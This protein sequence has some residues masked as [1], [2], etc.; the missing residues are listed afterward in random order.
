MVE[1]H[2]IAN[3]T[4]AR[5]GIRQ[6]RS[7]ALH[8][9]SLILDLYDLPPRL[10]RGLLDL[11]AGNNRV[12]VPFQLDRYFPEDFEPLLHLHEYLSEEFQNSQASALLKS[13]KTFSQPEVSEA[14][15]RATEDFEE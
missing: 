11:F 3:S 12:G 5:A 2:R 14:L 1:Y 15:R 9:D 10:E 6:L 7:I 4:I 8:L 13:H